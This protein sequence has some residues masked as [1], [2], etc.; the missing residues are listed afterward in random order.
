ME[1]PYYNL[2]QKFDKYRFDYLVKNYK[3]TI[4]YTI[5]KTIKNHDSIEM[6][7]NKYIFIKEDWDANEELNQITD[8]FT[9]KCRVMCKF[10]DKISPFEYW[11]K[12]KHWIMKQNVSDSVNTK[13]QII[14]KKIRDTIYHKTKLCNNFRISVSLTVLEFFGAKRWLDISAGWGDR[15]IAAIGA[16]LERYVGVDP[17]DCLQEYYKEIID[18]VADT[19]K[20]NR[21][22]ILQGGFE[23]I[24]LP[25]E[26]FDIVF[27]SPPFFDLEVYS[28]SRDDSLLNYSTKKQW[29]HNFLIPSLDKA[30]YHLDKNGW[31]VLYMGEGG[32]EKVLDKM[33]DHINEKMTYMGK[34]YYYYPEQYKPRSMLVWKNIMNASLSPLERSRLVSFP[35]E[36]KSNHLQR[37]MIGKGDYKKIVSLSANDNDNQIYIFKISMFDINQIVFSDTYLKD[38]IKKNID[39][40]KFINYKS[41]NPLTNYQGDIPLLITKL[42]KTPSY[43][44]LVNNYV[45]KLN[46]ESMLRY[47][48]INI[49]IFSN[50]YIKGDIQIIYQSFQ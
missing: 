45:E 4:E 26:K 18:T 9:E 7:D 15:L 43:C 31:L 17:N 39:N 28:T 40:H 16:N 12:N 6:F 19:D 34:I 11:N 8:I 20:R 46:I 25:N 50:D 13:N 24:E 23:K 5:P 27:S 41:E 14:L 37:Y 22:T 32:G 38:F 30:I 10:G 2:Y 42:D 29:Y 21:F 44:I 49:N 36:K 48:N 47:G 35:K 1:Y 33:I 3:K